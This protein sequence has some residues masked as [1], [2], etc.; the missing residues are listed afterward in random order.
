MAKLLLT[1]LFFTEL[2]EEV[3]PCKNHQNLQLSWI[4]MSN[5][6]R[7]LARPCCLP[8]WGI[9]SPLSTDSTPWFSR[10]LNGLPQLIER[11]N[12]NTFRGY[13]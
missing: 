2:M 10:L 11:E 1:Q 6:N 8:G 12:R 7:L 13:M 5:V 9:L 4:D 3:L